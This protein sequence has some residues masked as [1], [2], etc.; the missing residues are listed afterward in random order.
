MWGRLWDAA[1]GQQVLQGSSPKKL[2]GAPGLTTRSIL[3]TSNKR[4]LRPNSCILRPTRID[5]SDKNFQANRWCPAHL[6]TVGTPNQPCCCPPK[7]CHQG[8]KIISPKSST[9]SPHLAWSILGALRNRI[10][11]TP[12]AQS[13]TRPPTTTKPNKIHLARHVDLNK[14]P[15]PGYHRI[16]S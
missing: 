8:Q 11:S 2:L 16:S 13:F 6:L 4:S 7:M 5:W 3:T 12:F 10:H 1:S 15:L 9:C 14:I